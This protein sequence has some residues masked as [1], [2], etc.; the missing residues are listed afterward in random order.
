MSIS[1]RLPGSRL[2][3][4]P[5]RPATR[6]DA[7]QQIRIGCAVGEAEFE[8]TGVGN[9]DHVSPVVASVCDRVRRPSR[10]R[11]RRWGVEALVGIHRR[12]GDRRKRV[13]RVHDAAEEIVS[14]GRESELALEDR[15]T[16][17]CRSLDDHSDRCAWQPLPVRCGNGLG[18]KV[19]RSPCFS[20]IDLTMYLKKACR[21]AVFSAESYSQFISN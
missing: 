15:R 13:G 9:A 19:A 11:Q 4:M 5:S 6:R 12:I 20:A 3:L 21:S 1:R 10:A 8:T 2:F 7:W 18:M 17:S 16:R 14:D